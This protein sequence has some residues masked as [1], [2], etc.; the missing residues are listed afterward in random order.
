AAFDSGTQ[1]T[2]TATPAQGST[3]QGWSGG[4]CASTNPCTL[5][6]TANTTVVANFARPRFTLAVS[7]Q[8][9]G[10]GTVTSSP[11]GI[12]CG[13]TCSASFASGTQVTLTATPARGSTFDGWT[14]GGCASTNPCT[15]TLTANTT[16]TARFSVRRV[17]L[18]VF[19]Q[20]LGSGTVASSP[21]GIDCGATCSA[22]Y[23]SGTVVTL[24]ATPGLLSAFVGWSG[25]WSGTGP[26]TVPLTG[27]P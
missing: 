25:G 23:D 15:L 9:T 13:A 19:R 3:F 20:G 27:K 8:G 6:L 4:G 5:T 11:T 18:S 2:L 7:P 1:V 17:T 14:G 24:T 22:T 21:A 26:C 12:N 10:S 16:V